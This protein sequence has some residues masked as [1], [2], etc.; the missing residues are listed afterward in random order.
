MQTP[1]PPTQDRSRKTLARILAATERLLET[2]SF[3]QISIADIVRAARTSVGAF[4]TRFPTKDSL[5]PALYERYDERIHA[6][7]SELTAPELWTG[8]DLAERV[9]K[10]VRLL[11]AYY[12][13]H[14]GLM[15]TL[16]LHARLHPEALGADLIARRKTL[17]T[18]IASV[19]LE[20]RDEIR[21][22]A[23]ELAVELG[24]FTVAA[25]LRDKLLFG[26]PHAQ[27]IPDDT[28]L[29]ERELSRT[30]LAYLTH[31]E[32]DP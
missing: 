19:L 18:K 17:H 29:I 5:L 30:L 8:L 12:L 22:P 2:R 7:H 28:T 13:E 15:R 21:H 6:G 3:E 9:D 31:E 26:A 14:R 24:L 10:L 25:T 27:S 11:G 20:C 16:G 32:R 4:Y 1:V 23:P